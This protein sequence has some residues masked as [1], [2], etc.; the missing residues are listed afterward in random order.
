[1]IHEIKRTEG[2][3]RPD[4]PTLTD[5]DWKFMLSGYNFDPRTDDMGLFGY[6]VQKWANPAA[7]DVTYQIIEDGRYKVSALKGVAPDEVASYGSTL[8]DALI[9][10][11][12]QIIIGTKPVSYFDELVASWKSSGGNAMLDAMNREYGKK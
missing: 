1:M 9:E 7:F 3:I 12:T 10:G 5:D 11:F 2:K 8:Q 4:D 6:W